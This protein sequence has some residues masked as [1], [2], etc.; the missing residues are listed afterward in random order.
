MPLGFRRWALGLKPLLSRNRAPTNTTRAYDDQVFKTLALRF[1]QCRNTKSI[2]T[3]ATIIITIPRPSSAKRAEHLE[4]YETPCQT[5]DKPLSKPSSKKENN[6]HT[7]P[8]DHQGPGFA[9]QRRP[10]FSSSC[11]SLGTVPKGLERPVVALRFAFLDFR[12]RVEGLRCWR[13]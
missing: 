9:T 10:G 4:P 1:L 6:N 8:V 5:P 3:Q 7:N 12:F 13:F 2:E 11:A